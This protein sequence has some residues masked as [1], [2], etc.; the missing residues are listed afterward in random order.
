MEVDGVG[1]P[2]SVVFSEG[3]GDTRSSEISLPM[4]LVCP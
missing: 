4:P 3:S 1:S 2:L